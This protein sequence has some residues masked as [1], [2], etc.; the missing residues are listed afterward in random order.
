MFNRI[1]AGELDLALAPT[2][3]ERTALRGRLTNLDR[4]MVAATKDEIEFL[5]GEL[6][7]GFP[8]GRAHRGEPDA[9]LRMFR[10]A[11]AGI[12]TWAIRA[13]CSA[14]N[15]GEAGKHN[16]SFAPAPPDLREL[17]L[18]ECKLFRDEQT[19]IRAILAAEV[20]EEVSPEA[21]ERIAKGLKD[22]AARIGSGSDAEEEARQ[23]ALAADMRART[24]A[25]RQAEQKLAGY[26]DGLDMSVSL[27]RDIA[28][29]KG[30]RAQTDAEIEAWKAKHGDMEKGVVAPVRSYEEHMAAWAGQEAEQGE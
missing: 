6:L 2:E 20:V 22:L 17:A 10:Q 14:W 19:K 11:L 16:T 28:A 9:V 27:R 3:A 25:K 24:A 13:A 1:V 21:R 4:S 8:V 7:E 12:P 23:R 5:V 26:D 30:R 15:R 29:W 18:A